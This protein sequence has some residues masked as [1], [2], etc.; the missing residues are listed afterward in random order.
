MDTTEEAL[1]WL[2]SLPR[3]NGN[4][5]RETKPCGRRTAYLDARTNGGARCR[6]GV[7]LSAG[8]CSVYLAGAS[9][10]SVRK[11]L[12][13][14]R[15]LLCMCE[16]YM[17]MR[18][19]WENLLDPVHLTKC[20]ACSLGTWTGSFDILIRSHRSARKVQLQYITFVVRQGWILGEHFAKWM[21]SHRLAFQMKLWYCHN[22]TLK[23]THLTLNA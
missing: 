6:V 12:T 20:A 16:F 7:C 14:M 17:P 8:A 3:E 13:P 19:K 22:R 18:R 11:C 2:S 21:G 10:Q 9:Q 4:A 1:I 5:S 15:W 23:G